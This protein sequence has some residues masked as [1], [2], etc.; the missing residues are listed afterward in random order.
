VDFAALF[1]PIVEGRDPFET[2]EEFAQRQQQLTTAFNQAALQ[3]N[4]QLQAGTVRL[5]KRLY[6][7]EAGIFKLSSI[8]WLP[9]SQRFLKLNTVFLADISI[10]VKRDEARALYTEGQEKL[11][12][13]TL[14]ADYRLKT[15]FL[16]GID[17][18]FPLTLTVLAAGQ[19]FQDPLK[20]GGWGPKMV[21]IPKGSFKMGSDAGENNEKPVHKVTIG[22]DYAMSQYEITF[23]DYDRFCEATGR[24][25]PADQGWGR[26][27]RP[28][29]SVSWEDGKAYSQWLTEQTGNPYRLP[30]EAEWEYACR[31]GTTTAYSF[32]DDVNQSGNYAWYDK[33][34]GSQTHPVGEK[35]PNAFGL[36]DMHGNVWE[37]LEDVWHENYQGAPVD[38]SA[39][40]SGG[41]SSKHPLRGGS[42]DSDDYRLRCAY[43]FWDDTT[44][45]Y[46]YGG[47]RLS[48][49]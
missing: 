9:W 21:L 13:I 14:T 43:R 41:D 4:S 42:W 26:G 38:G 19:V 3:R 47:L 1:S 30:S 16:V 49:M 46:S 48:R 29:I 5:E 12:F 6:D 35:K 10:P 44:Y 20:D 11:L 40:M 34:S 39:W 7:V 22:Y 25:K 37:W 31:A 18:T 27:Q 36:Y 33:N 8:Q 17:R 23:D 28:V 32:G 24:A 15:A 2:K 45:G